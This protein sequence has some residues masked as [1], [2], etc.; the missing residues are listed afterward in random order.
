MAEEKIFRKVIITAA[1]TGQG[2]TPSP[3]DPIDVS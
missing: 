1:I 3:T 2:P